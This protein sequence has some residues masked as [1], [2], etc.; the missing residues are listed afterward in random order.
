M[1]LQLIPD[2][3][4]LL[5]RAAVSFRGVDDAVRELIDNSITAGAS[6]IS[7]T[8]HSC[9]GFS[10]W[11]NGSGIDDEFTHLGEEGWTSKTDGRGKSLAH[12]IALSSEV[13]VSSRGMQKNYG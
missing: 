3:D 13:N 1:S 10:V 11:D 8:V 6:E 2:D 9:N 5:I 4:A 7:V 12:L